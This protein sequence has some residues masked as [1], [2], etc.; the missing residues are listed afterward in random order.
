MRLPRV[1][2]GVCICLRVCL[3]DFWCVFTYKFACLC[4]CV[5]VLVSVCVCIYACTRANNISGHLSVLIRVIYVYLLSSLCVSVVMKWCFG[6]KQQN[7]MTIIIVETLLFYKSLTFERS[8]SFDQNMLHLLH[9]IHNFAE[10]VFH[11][12]RLPHFALI[13]M[14]YPLRKRQE[15]YC[16]YLQ[17]AILMTPILMILKSGQEKVDY[18]MT[19]G[20]REET[21][22]LGVLKYITHT[23]TQPP[24]L[25][26][27]VLCIH[28]FYLDLLTPPSL[29]QSHLGLF[30]FLL[31]PSCNRQ[32]PRVNLRR[33]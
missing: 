28:F 27:P 13:S 11:S 1:S 24:L 3:C 15:N 33:L 17:Q 23:L 19:K 20:D 18:G 2:L 26:P 12:L 16:D 9:S 5:L 6:R 14:L 25:L 8:K 22:R 32:D 31:L 7:T 29:V 21:R 4:V 30:L 10:K